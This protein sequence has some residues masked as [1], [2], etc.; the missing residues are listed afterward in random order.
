MAAIALRMTLPK[1]TMSNQI[2]LEDLSRDSAIHQEYDRDVLRHGLMSSGVYLGS[3]A[4]METVKAK[5]QRV[6]VPTLLQLAERDPVVSTEKNLAMF[7]KLGASQKILKVY[8][9]RKHEIYNDLGR[10]EVLSDLHDFFKSK[11]SH[12]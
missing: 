11:L 12:Q 2:R 5:I 1:I 6:K 10:E 9:D 3:L 4:A 7:K 8:P